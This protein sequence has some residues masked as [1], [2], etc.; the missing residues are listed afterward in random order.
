VYKE[1][2]ELYGMKSPIFA[3][4]KYEDRTTHALFGL[5]Y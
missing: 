2:L 5:R 3:P 4:V 1:L